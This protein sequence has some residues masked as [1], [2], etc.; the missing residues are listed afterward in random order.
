MSSESGE[1]PLTDDSFRTFKRVWPLDVHTEVKRFEAL[2]AANI[3][4]HE[5]FK[6]IGTSVTV[7]AVLTQHL[8]LTE[9][10]LVK[11]ARE[12]KAEK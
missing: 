5:D 3:G 9:T 1:V 7:W 8:R 6:S 11:L 2:V 12:W 10:E 4:A